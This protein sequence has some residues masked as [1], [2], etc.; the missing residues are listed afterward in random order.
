M[1]LAAPRNQPECQAIM[2]RAAKDLRRPGIGVRIVEV[3]V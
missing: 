1:S 2:H 3:S